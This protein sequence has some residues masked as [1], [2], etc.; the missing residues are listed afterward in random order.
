MKTAQI[1][2]L[3]DELTQIGKN[4]Q[5]FTCIGE[6]M[7]R[8]LVAALA[9]DLQERREQAA[10]LNRIAAE[11]SGSTDSVSASELRELANKLRE[12]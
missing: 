4:Y 1:R 11:I 7:T 3:A 12:Q 8:A 9:V 6:H 10:L 2:L 5:R